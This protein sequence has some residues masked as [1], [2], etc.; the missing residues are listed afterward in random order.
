MDDRDLTGQL[1]RS[2]SPYQFTRSVADVTRSHRRGRFGPRSLALGV[3]ALAA[4]ALWALTGTPFLGSPRVAFAGWQPMPTT[5][6]QA[7]AVAAKSACA[8]AST[9]SLV[10]QDQRGNAATLLYAGSGQLSICLVLRDNTGAVVAAA[11][12]A[13]IL[14]GGGGALVVD[15]GLS[16]PRTADSAG[17]QIVAGRVGPS[18]KAVEVARADGVTVD[19]TVSSGYFVAWWPTDDRAERVTAIDAVGATMTTVPGL[20]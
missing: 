3:T 18:V 20:N 6:D 13:T 16:A 8:A 12:G 5:A 7:L 2:F 11:S 4:I 9:M 19:A 14:E 1:R 15:T 17:L 10:A